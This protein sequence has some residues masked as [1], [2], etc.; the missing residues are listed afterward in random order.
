MARR[1]PSAT[2]GGVRGDSGGFTSPGGGPNLFPPPQFLVG[3]ATSIPSFSL[4][5][6]LPQRLDRY[7]RYNGSLTT[8]PCFQSVLWS[9]FQQPVLL[10]RAQLEQLRGSLY[11]TAPDEPEPE[12]LEENFRAPKTSTRGWCWRP[13]AAGPR[14]IRQV[15][16]SPSSSAPSSAASASSSPFISRARGCA[17]GAGSSRTWSSK[18]PRAA[19]LSTT[20]LEPPPQK[21]TPPSTRG[22]EQCRMRGADP[23]PPPRP[24]HK[25]QGTRSHY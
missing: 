9:V 25:A 17:R 10:S 23:F 13:S 24:P 20:G 15:K 2:L 3:Q 6:L 21:K 1:L 11:A 7:Y 16:S 8:P 18:P 22:W 19:R 12:R 5:G 4:R 14:A